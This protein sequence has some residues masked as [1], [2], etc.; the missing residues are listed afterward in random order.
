MAEPNGEGL[1]VPH[2]HTDDSAV[3][4]IG[5]DPVAG[6]YHR[7]YVLQQILFK[8]ND[9]AHLWGV[10]VT[11][12]VLTA[13]RR[14]IVRSREKQTPVAHCVCQLNGFGMGQTGVPTDE[15]GGFTLS[16]ALVITGNLSMAA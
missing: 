9:I 8:Q 6:F 7:D 11:A 1:L 4:S 5:D 3:I 12:S 13:K 16:Y 2:R 10:P 15:S 14:Y